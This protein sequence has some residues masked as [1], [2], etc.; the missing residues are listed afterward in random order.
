MGVRG[1]AMLLLAPLLFGL[2]GRPAVVDGGSSNQSLT[3]SASADAAGRQTD[4]P[5]R[6]VLRGRYVTVEIGGATC[7]VTQYGA[8]GDGRTDVSVAVLP[9]H[10]VWRAGG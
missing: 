6:R 2:L 3:M 7:D 10:A 5:P 8:V 4:A 9:Q 1:A